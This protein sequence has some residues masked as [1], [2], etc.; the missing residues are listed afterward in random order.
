MSRTI[1]LCI[2]CNSNIATDS[3]TRLMTSCGG[4]S[5]AFPCEKCGKLHGITGKPV[6]NRQGAFAFLIDRRIIYKNKKGEILTK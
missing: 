5:I 6:I 2:D 1:N 4:S 3:T